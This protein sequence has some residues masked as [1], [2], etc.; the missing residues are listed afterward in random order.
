MVN[1]QKSLG[2]RFQETNAIQMKTKEENEKIKRQQSIQ[3]KYYDVYNNFWKY[4]SFRYD[5][6]IN[7]V[8]LFYIH[9]HKIYDGSDRVI[10]KEKLID[11]YKHL[12]LDRYI[13]YDI[14]YNAV[15][16]FLDFYIKNFYP[17]GHAYQKYMIRSLYKVKD[18]EKK[19]TDLI[20]Y[21]ESTNHP[22]NFIYT[23]GVY[24][25]RI[26]DY[27]VWQ[28]IFVCI[29][30]LTGNHFDEFSEIYDAKSMTRNLKKN[31][32][33][34]IKRYFKKNTIININNNTKKYYNEYYEC[35]RFQNTS[36]IE[37]HSYSESL[38]K[39]LK[40]II[41]NN[42]KNL[43]ALASLVTA[44]V[45]PVN[46][47]KKLT[48]FCG[49][50]NFINL[51]LDF[52]KMLYNNKNSIIKIPGSGLF[53]T[54]SF[55][56]NYMI[57]NLPDFTFKSIILIP[58]LCIT[59]DF[60]D[61]NENTICPK[62][63]D[64]ETVKYIKNLIKS[65]KITYDDNIYG[66]ITYTNNIPI[67]IFTPSESDASTL[68]KTFD[69]NVIKLS[70]ESEYIDSNISK[71]NTNEKAYLFKDLYLYGLK[72]LESHDEK[73]DNNIQIPTVKDETIASEFI[74]RYCKHS[75][76]D[77]I[78]K[79]EIKK[80]YSRY[81]ATLFPYSHSGTTFIYD[82]LNLEGY[83][84][85]RKRIPNNVQPWVYIDLYFDKLKFEKDL[86][87]SDIF[88]SPSKITNFDKMI[89]GLLNIY[90]DV[91]V[92]PYNNNLQY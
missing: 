30:S 36:P 56:Y 80:L 53:D 21:K 50:Q 60:F 37:Q 1:N 19:H 32:I 38:I 35:C 26:Y 2:E 41:G 27:S 76:G 9:D 18:N 68:S 77:Y 81:I 92:V 13:D 14:F 87:K 5:I 29:I 79:V 65:R 82:K 17:C 89:D 88:D 55:N 24:S 51:T 25:V 11:K 75:T 46:K 31:V 58:E 69:A 70:D 33:N 62:K 42:E 28:P 12:L 47:L 61:K 64:H 74:S 34:S 44:S 91:K 72:L 90:K 67:V 83:K 10:T 15:F 52:I 20:T 23:N 6:Y 48:I 45:T 63:I 39:Y 84:N 7:P 4:F 40:I 8:N 57:A 73:K 59:D 78:K 22:E 86:K 85:S 3:T 43:N 71:V 49:S 66:K 16:D 54:K